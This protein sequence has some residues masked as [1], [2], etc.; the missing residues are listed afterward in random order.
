MDREVAAAIADLGTHVVLCCE[1]PGGV[2]GRIG[3]DQDSLTGSPFQ[4]DQCF[5][6][7]VKGDAVESATGSHAGSRQGA[8]PATELKCGGIHE[9]I[10][11]GLSLVGKQQ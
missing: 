1:V 3:D 9:E 8:G 2:A 11:T 4:P 5:T 10:L 6:V 7:A